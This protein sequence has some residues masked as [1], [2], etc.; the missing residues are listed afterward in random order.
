M[1]HILSVVLDLSR[2]IDVSGKITWTIPLTGE[3][4]DVELERVLRIAR[5][6][7]GSLA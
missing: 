2:W 7:R 3:Y 4:T 5:Q 1:S 6:S